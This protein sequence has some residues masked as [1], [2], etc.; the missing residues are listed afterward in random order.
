[1]A[2]VREILRL[3]GAGDTE[4]SY[5]AIASQLTAAARSTRH[6]GTWKA[7]TVRRIVNRRELYAEE[8]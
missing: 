5:R 7:E 1:M 2:T 4:A 6:G 8:T 3:P